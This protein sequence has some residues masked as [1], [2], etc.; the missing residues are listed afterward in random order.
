MSAI[1]QGLVSVSVIA[2]RIEAVDRPPHETIGQQVRMGD[3]LHFHITAE[4][5]Q[6]WLP[7]IQNIAEGNK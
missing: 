4:V 5:A 1:E 3:Y 7:V 6:Q 2:G